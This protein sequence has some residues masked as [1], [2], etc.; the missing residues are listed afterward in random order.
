MTPTLGYWSIRGIAEPIRYLLHYT[1]TEY[2][3]KQYQIGPDLATYKDAFR[4]EKDKLGL[5]FPNVPYYIDG[6][7]KI[8]ESR[9]I[10]GHLGRKNGLAGDC[11][12]DFF[13]LDVADGVLW[14]QGFHLMRLCYDP[15]FEMMKEPFIAQVPGKM[16]K[17]SKLVVDK[18]YILGDKICFLDFVL[19]ETLERYDALVPDCFTKFSSLVS[20]HARI[21]ALPAIAKY[22][23]SPAFRKISDRFNNRHAP[24]GHGTY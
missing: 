20:F 4:N 16:E 6:D 11:E 19:F 15:K 9:A 10:L 5:E 21:A 23:A 1:G 14:D 7:L 18:N 17:M 12:E 8:T 3:D 24:F 13:R 2:V 22:R